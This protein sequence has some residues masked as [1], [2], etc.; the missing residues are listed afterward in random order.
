MELRRRGDRHPG[1]TM[2]STARAAG[3][4][5]AVAV[6]ALVV[7]CGGGDDG[8]GGAAT[9]AVPAPSSA[10]LGTTAPT[11]PAPASG[12]AVIAHRGAS[13]YAPEHTFAAYD[14]AMAQGADYLE[15][16]LQLTA[17]GILV[18]LHDATLDRTARGPAGSCTGPVADKTLAQ[19]DECD[20]G[21]WFNETYPERADPAFVGLRIPTMAQVLERYGTDARYY[22]EIKALEAGSG[23][24]EP[25]LALLADAGLLDATADPAPVLVQSFGAEVLRTVHDLR[26]DLPLV[27]L[28]P[29]TGAPVDPSAVES[30]SEYAVGIGPPGAGTDPAVID[31]AHA[32]CLAVHPYTVDDPVE[33][34]RLLR[35]G[36]DGMFTNRPDVLRAALVDSPPLP[37]RCAPS[38]GR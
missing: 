18:V 38:A 35:A 32:R 9:S 34:D 13:A 24:E 21:S 37:D 20:V 33:M 7:S 26:P 19:L 28:L 23:M 4:V 14:L 25:L 12:A 15:Q 3:R 2:R 29:N 1:T 30:A 6:V 8:E 27:Q 16:D 22:I 5:A 31:A 17:D 11:T 10:A 36:V